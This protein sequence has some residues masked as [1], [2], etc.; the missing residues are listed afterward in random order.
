MYVVLR[1]QPHERRRKLDFLNMMSLQDSWPILLAG[2]TGH[3]QGLA[4]DPMEAGAVRNVQSFYNNDT[5]GNCRVVN[6]EN[7]SSF[8]PQ[9]FV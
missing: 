4:S 8:T 7:L 3:T 2:S 9:D 6:L 1:I 5:T